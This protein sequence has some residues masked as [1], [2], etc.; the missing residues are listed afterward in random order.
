MFNAT[1]T[2]STLPVRSRF[3]KRSFDPSAPAKSRVLSPQSRY[4][5][6][7]ECGANYRA[8]TAGQMLHIHSI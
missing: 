1:V 4:R 3:R 8:I 7:Y 5:D 6:H 2:I